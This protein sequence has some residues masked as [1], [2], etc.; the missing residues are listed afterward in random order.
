MQ[1]PHFYRTW[2]FISACLLLLTL[3]ILVIYRYRV[4]QVRARFEA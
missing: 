3:M 4:R 1:R 2:W